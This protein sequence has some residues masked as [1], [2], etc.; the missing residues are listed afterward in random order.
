MTDYAVIS[1]DAYSNYSFYAPLTAAVWR[2][3]GYTPLLLLVGDEKRWNDDPRLRIIADKSA[4]AGAVI[5]FLGEHPQHRPATVAQ[6]SRL[7]ACALSSTLTADDYLLTSDVDMWPLGSW[8]G[9]GRDPSKAFQLY[10][11]NAYPDRTNKFPICYIGARVR[12]WLE[13]MLSRASFYQALNLCAARPA[14]PENAGIF[15]RIRDEDIPLDVWTF[16]ETYFGECLSAW[17]GFPAN[18]QMIDRDMRRDGE[19]RLDRAGW[20]D[21]SALNGYA[22]AHLLRPG[23]SAENWSRVRRLFRLLFPDRLAWADAYHAALGAVRS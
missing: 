19:R 4:H 23:Y 9:G 2:A 12:S 5:C 15:H 20:V 7:Y 1:S 13:V 18:C 22:D 17:S 11:A 6:L 21:I 14:T 3:R 8:V 10:Y 16:D